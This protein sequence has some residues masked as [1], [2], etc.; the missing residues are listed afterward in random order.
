MTFSEQLLANSY[1]ESGTVAEVLKAQFKEY[2]SELL[3]E[4][5]IIDSKAKIADK[6]ITSI[7]DSI[8]VSS[9]DKSIV[10]VE[11][12]SDTIIKENNIQ[13]MEEKD[14]GVC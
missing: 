5:T 9:S 6:V 11:K 4:N 3:T 1:L 12:T 2:K 13:I 10:I 14:N 7:D 8:I